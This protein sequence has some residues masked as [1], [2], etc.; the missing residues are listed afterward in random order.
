MSK[1]KKKILPNQTRSILVKEM[2]LTRKGG[3]HI[4][5][6]TEDDWWEEEDDGWWDDED[7]Q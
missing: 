6:K 5:T 4:P 3:P 2:I 1:R 7:D